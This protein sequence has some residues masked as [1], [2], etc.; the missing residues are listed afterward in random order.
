MPASFTLRVTSAEENVDVRMMLND[1][2]VEKLT[3][4]PPTKRAVAWMLAVRMSWPPT[5]CPRSTMGYRCGREPSPFVCRLRRRRR[6]LTAES[7]SNRV[8]ELDRWPCRMS[9]CIKTAAS[10]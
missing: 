4:V 2:A 3:G 9:C 7:S 8:F 5:F 6:R 10:K 1:G